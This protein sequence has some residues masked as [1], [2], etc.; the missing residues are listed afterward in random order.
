MV[1]ICSWF[2]NSLYIIVLKRA[3]IMDNEGEIP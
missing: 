2:C 1:T 3:C